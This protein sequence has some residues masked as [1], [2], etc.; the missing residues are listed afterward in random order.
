MAY[1]KMALYDDLLESV[2]P[3]DP[4][5]ARALLEYFPQPLRER[6]RDEMQKHPL[7][8][9]II[10]TYV[11]NATVNR[12]GTSFVHRLAEETGAPPADV[13]R[14][15]TSV[16]E[17]FG[18]PSLWQGIE[19]LDNLAPDEVQARMLLDLDRLVGRATLWFLRRRR[20]I[21]DLLR[22]DE[23]QALQARQDAL[24]STGVP[25]ELARKVASVDALFAALDLIDVATETGRDVP[26]A[27]AVYF[28]LDGELDYGWL[29]T[30]IAA[31]GADD[32]W[33]ALAKA[34]LEDDLAAQQRTLTGSVLRLAPELSAVT[35]LIDT[36][37]AKNK[38]GVDRA[39]Q[40]I[41]DL[42]GAPGAPD[43][44]M[45]SVA[46]RELRALG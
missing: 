36:W 33:D 12:A 29:R 41:A 27:A 46:M 25:S 6:Y 45:L 2:L 21:A 39:R 8:R 13:V 19:A 28:A 15:Y 20:D 5:F 34:A 3:E 23:A 24:A 40:V 18:L 31:L 30:Q 14:A 17:V 32:H 42:H 1:S 10:A 7:K 16:R 11:T 22:V 35:S 9:E 44:A 37:I 43:L 38:V 26:T 4:F